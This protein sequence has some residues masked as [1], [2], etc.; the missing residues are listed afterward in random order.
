M[1]NLT[2]KG[3]GKEIAE[4]LTYSRPWSLV[5]LSHWVTDLIAPFCH[6]YTYKILSCCLSQPLLISHLPE[7][8]FAALNPWLVEYCLC[9]A[10]NLFYY[11]FA[12]FFAPVVSQDVVI[13][14]CLPFAILARCSPHHKGLLSYCWRGLT[15]DQP[16]F[17]VLFV[18]LLDPAKQVFEQ[19]LI[20]AVIMLFAFLSSLSVLTV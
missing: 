2:C 12:S 16:S 18:L 13:Y 11:P 9:I 15:W 7:L 5:S 14:P 20:F 8:W 19:A 4:Y 10:L 1:T 17:I 6:Q 3:G